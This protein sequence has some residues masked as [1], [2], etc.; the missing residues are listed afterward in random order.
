MR[1]RIRQMQWRIAGASFE[2]IMLN[3][4]QDTGAGIAAMDV[5]HIFERFFR[6]D[7]ARSQR[8]AGLGLA[9]VRHLVELQGGSVT[10]TSELGG[11][12][13]ISIA[14]PQISPVNPRS[15]AV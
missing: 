1:L 14:L 9:I 5:P 8:G 11:G 6:A 12:T 2:Q 7:R 13:T 10:A 4:V 15:S 3:A